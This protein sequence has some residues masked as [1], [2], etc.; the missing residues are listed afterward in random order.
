VRV[1]QRF[2]ELAIAHLHQERGWRMS[3]DDIE[4]VLAGIG[5]SR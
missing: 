5:V 4:K 3:G 2:K 1:H